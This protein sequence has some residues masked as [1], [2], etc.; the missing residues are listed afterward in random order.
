MNL[1][2][3]FRSGIPIYLQVVGRIGDDRRALAVADWIQQR[4]P[5]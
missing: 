1:E 2:I 3:D 4:I 5:N